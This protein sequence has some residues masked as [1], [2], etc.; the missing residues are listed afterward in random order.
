MPRK[1][2]GKGLYDEV[3]FGGIPELYYPFMTI[4][5]IAMI[6]ALGLFIALVSMTSLSATQRVQIRNA[7]IGMGVITILGLFGAIVTGGTYYGT[8]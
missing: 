7:L 5:I 2:R 3:G 6:V 4:G 8:Y 1:Q